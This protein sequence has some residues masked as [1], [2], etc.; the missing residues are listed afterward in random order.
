M[1]LLMNW[2]A[3]TALSSFPEVIWQ[4][5][6][7]LSQAESL[8]G[9]PPGLFSFSKSTFLLI[10]FTVPIPTPVLAVWIAPFEERD[11]RR[12]FFS[13][14]GLH[15]GGEESRWWLNQFQHVKIQTRSHDIVYY[16]HRLTLCWNWRKCWILGWY[17]EGQ[18]LLQWVAILSGLQNNEFWYESHDLTWVGKPRWP[19][20]WKKK[21]YDDLLSNHAVMIESLKN[22]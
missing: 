8:D 4:I 20:F 9:W 7:C 19:S 16:S 14:N 12:A 15:G 11:D 5:I 10:L 18:K 3:W 17:M 2:V 22:M 6:D 1:M 13:R 21:F